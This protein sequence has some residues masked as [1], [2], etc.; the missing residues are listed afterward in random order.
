MKTKRNIETT[1]YVARSEGWHVTFDR[2]TLDFAAFI[3]SDKLV[4]LGF[5]RSRDAAV[6]ACRDYTFETLARAA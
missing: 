2:Q 1:I 5:Y 3:D 4:L 6:K